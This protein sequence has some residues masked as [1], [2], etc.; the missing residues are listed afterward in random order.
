MIVFVLNTLF[1]LLA[2]FLVLKSLEIMIYFERP[3]K[4]VIGSDEI[5]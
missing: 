2:Y 4:Y 1:I 3:Y 5:D